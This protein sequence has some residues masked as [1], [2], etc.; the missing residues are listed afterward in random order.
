MWALGHLLANGDLAAL[1]LFGARS[2]PGRWSEFIPGIS[3]KRPQ[4]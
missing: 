3:V 1:L 2:S 4:T